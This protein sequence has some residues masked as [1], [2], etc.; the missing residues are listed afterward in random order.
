M[1]NNVMLYIDA[2]RSKQCVV[3]QFLNKE[4]ER[5]GDIYGRM[6]KVPLVNTFYVERL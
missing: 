6:L 5:N 2:F 1:K 4:S 3:V